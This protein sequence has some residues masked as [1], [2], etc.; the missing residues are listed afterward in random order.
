MPSIGNE[1]ATV[2][3]PLV[4]YSTEIGW[5]YLS[6]DQALTLR[7]GESGALL[8][9]TLRDKLVSL[10]PGVVTVNNVDEVIARIES[11]RNNIEGN[12]EVLA[13]LRGERSIYVQSEK[14]QRNVMLIDFSHPTENIFH[15][16]DEWQYTNG[17][18]T[19][20]ADVMFIINGVPVA[21]VE[22]KSATKKDGIDEGITQIRRYHRET[23]ELMTSPQVFD[24]THIL[25]FYYGVTW[26]LDRKGLFNWKDEEKG[27]FEKKVKRFFSR[28]RFL[29]FL[30]SWIVFYKKDD[31]LRKIVLRQHQT[32]AVEK[33][34]ERALDPE[35]KTG[36]VWHTQGSGKTF[37]MIKAADLILRNLPRRSS[38]ARCQQ[39]ET[40]RGS[41]ASGG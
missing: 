32:R 39:K 30:E 15:V 37:T 19:N 16:T 20:R 38:S 10:N 22:T 8:Y 31:E 14:R 5:A 34:V 18:Y 29:K 26:N 41:A 9:Q 4:S 36:L 12:A 3:N 13:W 21:I 28:E 27:N 33:V 1:R 23:P 17:K 11:A 25:D 35:K 2:Q 24:V 40:L 6:P 7:R